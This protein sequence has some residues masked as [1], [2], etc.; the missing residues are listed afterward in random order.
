M[1]TKAQKAEEISNISKDLG[2]LKQ[3]SLSISRN[4]C[5]TNNILT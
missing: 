4:G 3:L 5:G 2:A 1:M